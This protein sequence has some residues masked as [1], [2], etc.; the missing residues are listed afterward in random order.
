MPRIPTHDLESAPEKAKPLLEAVNKQIGRVPNIFG[1]IA[2]SPVALEGYLAMSG[3]LAK[4]ALPAWKR[5]A[6]P[7]E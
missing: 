7:G 4:G 6:M 1:T 2:N 5:Q 3:A